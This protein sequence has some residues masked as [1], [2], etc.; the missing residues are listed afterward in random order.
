MKRFAGFAAL[1]VL[2]AA[3]TGPLAA[4]SD[5]GIPFD[6]AQYQLEPVAEGFTRPL[7][8]TSAGDESGRLFVLEQGGRVWI[9]RDGAALPTPFLDISALVSTSANERGLLGLAF[10][11]DYADNGVFY[12]HYSGRQPDGDT[13]LARY[14][15][16]A[17]NP[18]A[19]DPASAEIIF[20]QAQPYANHNGGQIAFGPDGYL[21]LGLG[22]GGSAGDPRNL[23]QTPDVL[24]GKLLRLDVDSSATYA[25][26][27]DNPAFTV[28]AALAPEVW[29]WGLR[30]PW[31]FSFDRATG[32][33]YIADVGQNQWEEIN[34]Q[35]ADSAGGENYGWRV[36]EGTHRFS[37]EAEPAGH[38]LPI[39]EYSHAEGC[40]VTGGYVYRG[41]ALPA[42]DGVYFFADY[43]YGRIWA[44]YQDADGAFQTAVFIPDT[45]MIISSFGLDDAGELYVIDHGQGRVLKLIAR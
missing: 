10:H 42:L 43:C 34:F 11:P 19:A 3:L 6:P 23:A 33:L 28:N 35:P 29:A 39:F 8:L 16:S 36:F 13:V 25:A 24:L 14:R 15:V 37:N 27:P 26:P 32:D 4:Q 12:V 5:A 31:R 30:N 44:T 40:S 38:V 1:L 18:D 45:D 21:Y 41:A 22:D 9:V 17:D 2:L 20:T 7:F